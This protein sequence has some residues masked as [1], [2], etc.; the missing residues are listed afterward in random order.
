MNNLSSAK[1]EANVLIKLAV[2]I[3]SALVLSCLMSVI[4]TVMAGQ[5]SAKDLA[6]VSIGSAIW[7]MVF[8]TMNG[9]LM[10]LTPQI[11]NLIGRKQQYLIK[12]WF[13]GGQLFALIIM[14]FFLAVSQIGLNIINK[15]GAT[16]ETSQ[17]AQQYLMFI[18]FGLPAAALFQSQRSLSEGSAAPHHVLIVTA[19]GL[20]LNIPLNYLFIHGLTISTENATYQLIDAYGGAG[21]G[22]ASAIVLWVILITM[23]GIQKKNKRL[24]HLMTA[25]SS[26]SPPQTTDIF[27][28]LGRIGIPIGLAIFA[29]VSVFTY[30]PL[31]I[32]HL[33]E[34]KVAAHQIALNVSS[35]MFMVPLGP[36]SYTNLTLPTILLV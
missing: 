7:N 31:V 5:V 8:L 21:C 24:Q 17:L 35:V 9:V 30:I 19:M 10:S 13:R 20:A 1:S 25:N 12:P 36:V 29:E 2:P 3:V 34:D 23:S 6:A 14:L 22:I 26:F 16:P 15:L 4:D 11:A 27:K 18:L 33:G 28:H 32:A